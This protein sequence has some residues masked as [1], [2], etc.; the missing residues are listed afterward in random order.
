[1]KKA[2]MIFNNIPSTFERLT[3]VAYFEQFARM[4]DI[5]AQIN[6]R[7]LINMPFYSTNAFTERYILVEEEREEEV[8]EEEA[9]DEEAR[10]EEAEDEIREEETTELPPTE[11]SDNPPQSEETTDPPKADE[12]T[13]LSLG[14]DDSSL[15]PED[16]TL[17]P[18]TDSTVANENSSEQFGVQQFSGFE[19]ALVH[20]ND[21]PTHLGDDLSG[22]EDDQA[23]LEDDQ[24]NNVEDDQGNLENGQGNLEDDQVNNAE[25]DQ[26]NQEDDPILEEKDDDTLTEKDS[27]DYPEKDDEKEQEEEVPE[28]ETL[29]GY[30]LLMLTHADA[31][32]F[33]RQMFLNNRRTSEIEAAFT[34]G[35]VL[36]SDQQVD[37]QQ[38][39]GYRAQ[40]QD[41]YRAELQRRFANH[42]SEEALA[43]IL[44]ADVFFT[45]EDQY[46]R[47]LG[48][49]MFPHFDARLADT[50]IGVDEYGNIIDYDADTLDYGAY[51]AITPMSDVDHDNIVSNPFALRFNE[52]ESV[53][54]NT[55]ASSYRINVLSLP[56]R[57]DFNLN[58]DLVYSSS[59][60]YSNG[61]NAISILRNLHG[62]G[63]G[64]IFDLPYIWDNV[65]YVPGRGSFALSGNTIL[66]Y[67]LYDMRLHNDTTFTSGS[68]RS[69]RRLAFHNGTSY[70]FSGAHIIGMV[71]RFGNTIRF[72]YDNVLQFNNLRLLSRIFDT[73]DR[74][75]NFAY[76]YTAAA[77]GQFASRAIT[78]TSPDNST[79]VIN[80]T[81]NE[82]LPVNA[83]LVSSIQNQVG[84]VTGFTYRGENVDLHF[85]N[86]NPSAVGARTDTAWLLSR[87]NYPSGA[88]LRFEYGKHDINLGRDGSRHLWRVSSRAL[89]YNGREYQ[90][91]TFGYEGDHT[92][93]PQRVTTPPENHTYSTTVTKNTGVQV[94]HTFNH[95]HLNIS[96]RTYNA[97]N[98]LRLNQVMAYNNDRLPISIETTEH[99]NNRSRVTTQQFTYNRYGQITQVVSP[100]AQGSTLAR[101]QTDYT[102]DARFGL[103]LTKTSRPNAQTTV[104]KQNVLSSDGRSIVREYV[105]ENNVRQTRMDFTHDT[106]GNIV[107]IHEFY[108]NN[109]TAFTQTQITYSLGTLPS[110]I[111][112]TD[113]RNADGTLV[114]NIDRQFTYDTMWR[115]LTETDPNGYRTL[116]QYDR[117]G[118]ITRIT[119]PNGG[120]A[121]YAYDDQRN[122][123]THRT[124][125]GA[126]YTYQY[127]GLGKLVSVTVGGVEILRNIYDTRMRISETRNAQRINSSQRTVFTYDVFH[128]VTQR[129]SL[130]PTG[131]ELSR[132]STA[133]SD[134][135]DAEGNRRITTTVTGT[136]STTGN[137]PTIQTFV[138]YDRFGRR[139]Q[140]GT[141]GGRITTFTH[142]LAGRVVTEQSLGVNNTFTYN[143]H[144]VT[145]VR[146][147]LGHTSQNAY[148]MMGR[149]VSSTD[150][151]GN[152]Q[153]FTYDNLSRLITHRVPFERSGNTAH[154]S[155]VRYFYDN[156]SN[157]IRQSSLVN[158]PG[159][160][161]VWATTENTFR[162]NQLITST[163]GGAEG[164]RTTYIY[165]LAGNVLTKTIGGATTSFVYNNR[166]QLTSTTD[167][168]GQTETFAYDANGHLITHV[169]RN[170]TT[171]Q[172]TYDNLGRMIRREALQNGVVATFRSY[173]FHPT[174]ALRTVDVGS[175]VMT[176]YYDAQGRVIRQTETGGVVK[177]FAYNTANNLTQ[178]RVYINNVLQSNDE[179]T[180]D[181]AQRVQTVRA[182]GELIATYT[183]NA[184]N[185][186]ISTVSSNNLTTTYTHNLSGLVTNVINRHGSTTLSS[187]D[188]LYY[189]DG[190]TRQITEYLEGVNRTITY[191]YDLARRLVREHVVSDEKPSIDVAI[192]ANTWEELR[193]AINAAP[194][195][196]QTIIQI[197]GNIT[198]PTGTAG[199]VISVSANRDIVLVSSNANAARQVVQTNARQRHFAISQGASLTL[200]RGIT[201]SGGARNNTND[202]G[203]V[204]VDTGG[205]LT[206]LDGSVIENCMR[207]TVDGAVHLQ[208]LGSDAAGSVTFNMLG[209]SIRYNSGNTTGGVHILTNSAFNMSGGLISGNIATRSTS[210]GGGVRLN[211]FNAVFNM[212]GGTISGNVQTAYAGGRG[213]GGVEVGNGTFAM[214]GGSIVGNTSQSEIGAGGVLVIH[215]TF[216][217]SGDARIAE[218]FASGVSGVGG[219]QLSGGNT[220][221]F[222]MNGGIIGG[223][224]K[225]EANTGVNAGGVRINFGT[226][227]MNSGYISNNYGGGVRLIEGADAVARFIM[228]GGTINSN[229]ND[230]QLGAGVHVGR[231]TFTQSGGTI[232]NNMQDGGNA[233][234]SGGGGVRVTGGTFTMNNTAARIE[235]NVASGTATTAGGGGIRHQGGT[236]NITAGT[237]T[238][239]HANRQGGGI[240]SSVPGDLHI[241]S[242]AII[243]GNTPDDTNTNMLMATFNVE[244]FEECMYYDLLQYDLPHD[245]LMNEEDERE[246]YYVADEIPVNIAQNS[247]WIDFEPFGAVGGAS[248]HSA[249]VKDDGTVWTWGSN[250]FGGLGDGTTVSRN[251]PMQVQN[252]T[253]VTAVAAG[254][255]Q[256]FALREDGTVWAWGNNQNGRL[257]DGTT[258]TR[259][260]PVQVQNL[261]NIVAVAASHSHTVALRDDGTVWAW[262]ANLRGQLGDGTTTQRTT[263]V[264]VQNLTNVIAISAGG[265]QTF[266]LRADGTVWA[267]GDN[268][269]GQLGD[270]TTT[271]RNTP[272]QVQ[273]LANVISISSAS[274]SAFAVRADGTV[275][276]WGSNS[277]GQLGDGTTTA[278]HTP[279][280]VPNLT[281]VVDISSA[282]NS[283]FAL[284]S[285]GTAWA[286]GSNFRGLLG[287]GMQDDSL[288][289]VRVH[290]LTNVSEISGGGGHALAI[291]QEG[292]VWTWGDN[293]NGQLGD[294]TTT[295][296]NTP[297]QVL[298][299]DGVG[300]LNLRG[301]KPI[302]LSITREYTFDNRGNRLTTIVTGAENYTVAYTYD[303]NNRL[304]TSTRMLA[305]GINE[306]TTFIYDHNGNQLTKITDDV[307]ETKTY[308]AFNQLIIVN[309]LANDTMGDVVVVNNWGALQNAINS[310]RENVPT[311][312]KLSSS[313]LAPIGLNGDAIIIPRNR[314][315][316]LTSNSEAERVITQRNYDQRHF[317]VYGS[318]TLGNGITLSG[319]TMENTNN[320][321]GVHVGAG[322]ILI[323]REGS[324]IHNSIRPQQLGGGVL[325]QSG[326]FVMTGGMI[327]NNMAS[328]G[329]GVA[330]THGGAFV[331]TGGA[332]SNNIADSMGGGVRFYR[333]GT[334][335]MHG[336]IISNNIVT[337]REQAI[338][339]GVSG[340]NF[341]MYGG[342]I[343]NNAVTASAANFASVAYGGGVSGSNFTMHGGIIRNNTVTARDLG[344]ASG[345]GV[346][347]SNFTMYGG[348]ISGNSTVVTSSSLN[349]AFAGGVSSSGFTMHGGIISNN[350]AA[351]GGGVSSSNFTMYDGEISNNT[352][353]RGGGGIFNQNANSTITMHGGTI[354]GNSVTQGSGGGV[355][356]LAQNGKFTM[357]GGQVI[358]NTATRSGGGICAALENVYIG[359][360]AVVSGNTPDDMRSNTLALE[361]T[362]FELNDNI[363]I[364]YL[365]SKEHLY[366]DVSI[367]EIESRSAWD[368]S[369]LMALI[370]SALEPLT[371]TASVDMIVTYTYR[372]DGLRHSKTVNGV[373]TT[374]IWKNGNIV[375]ELNE[376]GAV[377]GRF[378]RSLTGRIIRSEQH[379]YYL[380][381]KRGDVVQRVNAQG[382][383]IQ[384]YRYTAF[385]VELTPDANSTNPFRFASMYWDAETSTYYTPYRNFNPRTGRWTSPDPHWN[386]GNMQSSTNAILQ[387]GNLF[388][389][390][391]HN[392]V[393]WIDPLGL[394]AVQPLTGFFLPS[395]AFQ[396]A[397]GIVLRSGAGTFTCSVTGFRGTGSGFVQW[398]GGSST[399]GGGSSTVLRNVVFVGNSPPTREQMAQFDM[400][401]RYLL[402]GSAKARKL[403]SIIET[404]GVT[405]T[406]RF[407]ED[408]ISR[409]D[410]VTGVIWWDPTRGTMLPDGSIRSAA[411]V[412][413][414]ELGHFVQWLGGRFDEYNRLHGPGM[415]GDEVIK[416][417][418]TVMLGIERDNLRDWETPIAGQLG[419]PIRHDY[420]AHR[421]TPAY[422][423]NNPTHH[424]IWHKPHAHAQ[425]VLRDVN[426]R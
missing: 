278:R 387:A 158:V 133:F 347:G 79:F 256:T 159:Q 194:E 298:G 251:T 317:V 94:V 291:R 303:L 160:A 404:S 200:G 15:P 275:W 58:L 247:S 104:V 179:Y 142:D 24:V 418:R 119:L 135:F 43:N 99:S 239:N 91:T 264:Q 96:Q 364:D 176:Y 263:P 280:Q 165:D 359:A 153:R 65:L 167:A 149:I 35:E 305:G 103:L 205:T 212:S 209:G 314:N 5:A 309:V 36:R 321:G 343:K 12:T 163:T 14:N 323:M 32:D 301:A 164:I 248:S 67:T 254:G 107:E 89:Y 386:I 61:H 85:S 175:H 20:L 152:T 396:L 199:N 95:R 395:G 383:V 417:R 340:N 401:I 299:Q 337:N 258:T 66:E 271:Q 378:D 140:E 151:M 74:V 415:V 4:F 86:K 81:R 75:I 105:Y 71:D 261:T 322:G 80:M 375:L 411:N 300:F 171:F 420:Y 169:D 29:D 155:E 316:T 150:F 269:F 83:F 126:T 127:S 121:T 327:S 116:F 98:V 235:S 100:L 289:P 42:T 366:E 189:L 201:L 113:V 197:A 397:N 255:S 128:R 225:E 82:R 145:S 109:A 355:L 400:A 123:L 2:Q 8:K 63:E 370:D 210:N 277:S 344:L 186:R 381:N 182:N 376:S 9:E 414:H 336:G 318:L 229:T 88:Q 233:A 331:M 348:E 353:D 332:I 156:N 270:G 26:K 147:I 223:F 274:S 17:L 220:G 54:L 320:S 346:S 236:V 351:R 11:E 191:T 37:V 78:I 371:N 403:I 374:Y 290:N 211:A 19:S 306:V 77:G 232:R 110:L 33:A 206:M 304:L 402:E 27:E 187:F 426:W 59:R 178:S 181:A 384:N 56:G 184:N 421:L 419:E 138:Q 379:G 51:Q 154:Y 324:T 286:W 408:L 102:F 244:T 406:I 315:I 257:G 282:N 295:H 195:N 399:A 287:D 6:A 241:G 329:G 143:V 389:Y 272:V 385:G 120:F 45:S 146:N 268:M 28:R 162:H 177:T 362:I 183:Y 3:E 391:M 325:V 338:G 294:G 129:R 330:V 284:R 34:Y 139:T 231:G 64:W 112:R 180:F 84:A 388:M 405:F 72:E 168:L 44:F 409:I 245:Q 190:N 18:D 356:T 172:M 352:A 203:G 310:A 117:L 394:S 16:S 292:T 173:S 423:M 267:W 342:E 22:I 360:N 214:S 358:N 237:I 21:N 122:T 390:T 124:V 198:T 243:S 50:S 62:L 38:Q 230:G 49:L 30:S 170:G 23:N 219:V 53:S 111:R 226:F 227:T 335:V 196:A 341:K 101:Y 380:Y 46:A 118:R 249:V 252:L 412:L 361:S 93:F 218:N 349:N 224:S 373:T 73:N 60:A 7:R 350:R 25:E 166:G 144:G 382:Q 246:K 106:F 130:S 363:H 108:A 392:P 48:E 326:A 253:N 40:L 369:T 92:A 115:P 204:L 422:R 222:T 174:G 97:S 424:R 132:E 398:L 52:S 68:L 296:R 57:N 136:G 215:G 279:G 216:T 259:H 372:A 39:N 281:N 311:T 354:S 161:Q 319:G 242:G 13:D 76:T 283:V 377:I 87:V 125:L 357:H 55:G 308:N 312:V 69:N 238:N 297:V 368:Q 413:A 192:T 260:L 157:I 273:N 276:A 188:Y 328:S 367:Y 10:E 334:F 70:F 407:N 47:Y 90:R 217:M 114:G 234:N 262:G 134:V 41:A 393:R 131:V 365:T 425:P 265:N 307:T 285:D 302:R 339:G 213:A 207:T 31:F 266:A 313:A 221:N 1:M 228:N 410:P 293:L 345:G 202:S 148:D 288:V 193:I 141:T 250:T 333:H 240:L 185:Q 208:G 416:M 137:A